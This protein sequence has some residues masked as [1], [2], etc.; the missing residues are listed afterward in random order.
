MVYSYK[1]YSYSV[2]AQTVG[3]CFEKIE[4]KYG[5][6]TNDLVLDDAKREDSPLHPLFEWDDTV[7]AHKYRLSQATQLILNL[8]VETEVDTTVR[9]VRAYFNTSENDRKGTFIN[10]NS[11]FENPDTRELVLKRALRELEIFRQKYESL[12]ELAE[13]FAKIDEL[14]KVV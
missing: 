11:A 7:A 12:K 2:P 10:V 13:I 3:K 8:H 9:E 5:K 1:T 4:K 14:K 6:V